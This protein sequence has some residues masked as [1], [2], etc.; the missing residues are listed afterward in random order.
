MDTLHG[1]RHEECGFVG[2]ASTP[3]RA[4][5]SLRRH[6]CERHRQLQAA[7]ARRQAGLARIDRSPK[8]CLH[9]RVRHQ[10]G[11]PACYRHDECRCW[12]CT[13]A[14]GAAR[15]RRRRLKGYGRDPLV[16]AGPA[17]AHVR[18]L[19]AAG[20]SMARISELSG[21]A[22]S[23]LWYILH[24]KLGRDGVRRPT[25]RLRR[26]TAERILAV[27]AGAGQ[28]A[29]DDWVDATG[30]RRRLQALAFL[31]WPQVRL[32]EQIG[33]SADQVRLLQLHTARTQKATAE[34]AIAAYD[35]L[36]NTQPPQV[37]PRQRRWAE[38]TRAQARKHRWA[39]PMAWDDDTIDDQAAQPD[40]GQRV[41]RS[42]LPAADDLRFLLDAGESEDMI[43]SRFG[44]TVSA[45]KRA[46]QRHRAAQAEGQQQHVDGDAEAAA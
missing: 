38:H 17:A 43:A 35:Q 8:P 24:G 46:L 23:V 11:T 37:S 32:A 26:V 14:S 16:D 40:L 34:R 15:A 39:P 30:T 29:D 25:T 41:R 2:K 5:Y 1:A 42:K 6:S 36:W 13:R 45:V 28:V 44:V 7:R 18:E 9:K 31:G 33:I 12:P 4:A 22:G 27:P 10:H 19:R 3:G 20:L 21:V